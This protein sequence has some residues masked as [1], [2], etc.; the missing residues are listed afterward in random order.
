LN[1]VE[2]Q[3]VGPGRAVAF[4]VHSATGAA[5]SATVW[6]ALEPGGEVPEHT[7]SAEELLLVL[8]GEVEAS[9]DGETGTLRSDQLAVIPPMAP[10]AL[11]NI[12]SGDARVLGFF[13]SS[14]VVSIFTDP[15][16]PEGE[17]VFVTGAPLRLAVRLEEAVTLTA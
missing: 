7:D 2:T 4:P 13:A 9:V 12:G 16:G 14:A 6:I 15:M 1:E 10:H 8:D 3:S 11:R 17:Q 5:A